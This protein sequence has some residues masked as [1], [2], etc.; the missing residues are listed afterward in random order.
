MCA[1]RSTQRYLSVV[2]SAGMCAYVRMSAYL[3]TSYIWTSFS[4]SSSVYTRPH[5]DTGAGLDARMPK[6]LSPGHVPGPATAPLS[7][8]ALPR[9]FLQRRSPTQS[10]EAA[11]PPPASA[12]E[13]AA[14]PPLVLPRR[15]PSHPESPWTPSAE[16]NSPSPGP[17]GQPVCLPP[18]RSCCPPSSVLAVLSPGAPQRRPRSRCGGCGERTELLRERGLRFPL[19]P[20]QPA[21]S[22]SFPFFN[23]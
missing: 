5:T 21:P 15:A 18:A 14:S 13:P 10:T 3:H 16:S 2:L 11:P 6:L 12:A 23:L 9:G 4:L 20:L 8:R 19:P 7:P 1:R 22:L 17:R